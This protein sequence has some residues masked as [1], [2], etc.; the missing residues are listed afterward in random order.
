MV[1]KNKTMIISKSS[2]NKTK[3]LNHKTVLFV[4]PVII[5]GIFGTI[6]KANEEGFRKFTLDE[7]GPLELVDNGYEGL[8]VTISESVTQDHCNKIINNL[9]VLSFSFNVFYSLS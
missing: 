8:V 4:F 2:V 6:A 3:K 1:F 7:H 9:K 5:F